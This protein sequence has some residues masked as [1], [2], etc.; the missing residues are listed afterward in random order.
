M[1]NMRPVWDT[2][3]RTVGDQYALSIQH[4]VNKLLQS[5][6]NRCTDYRECS[7]HVGLSGKHQEGDNL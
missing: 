5:C 4:S 3:I 1:L 6:Q 7:H 2:E